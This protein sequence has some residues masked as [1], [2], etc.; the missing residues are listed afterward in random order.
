M[1]RRHLRR[2]HL[3]LDGHPHHTR[4]ADVAHAHAG[5]GLVNLVARADGQ[6]HRPPCLFGFNAYTH[7]HGTARAAA[8]PLGQLASQV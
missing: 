5:L 1:Q 7:G 2:L 6:L 4:A 3:I 8:R